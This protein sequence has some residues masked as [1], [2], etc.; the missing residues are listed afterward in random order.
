MA[1]SHVWSHGQGGRPEA[2]V[3]RLGL[4]SDYS[5]GFNSCLHARYRVVAKKLGC[6]AYWMDTP[7]I[8]GDHQLRRDAIANINT[9]FS[10]SLLTLICDQDI[11]TI[12]V[13]NLTIEV[14][15]SILATLMVCDWNMRA[16]TLLEAMRSRKNI[17][18]LCKNDQT[19]SLMEI[20][21]NVCLR[22]DISIAIHYLTAQHLLPTFHP[23]NSVTFGSDLVY[24][25]RI[26]REAAESDP[27]ELMGMVS[28]QEAAFLLRYRH[29]SRE[30]D[31]VIIRD[32]LCA[33]A[34]CYTSGCCAGNQRLEGS[35]PGSC[36]RRSFFFFTQT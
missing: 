27:E 15:E 31:E 3:R 6:D 12:D 4:R 14:Q 18:L 21:R 23:T 24:I 36:S 19:V 8:P 30:G 9:V 35:R 2:N 10:E 20:L 22:G 26:S 11:M 34:I 1:I 25:R 29:A 32:L 33:E 13:S 28:A 17:Q 16:W 5:G 7:C